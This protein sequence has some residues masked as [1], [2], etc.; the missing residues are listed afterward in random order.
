MFKVSRRPSVGGQGS[1]QMR[2]PVDITIILASP[3]ELGVQFDPSKDALLSSDGAYKAYKTV[4]VA[5]N[6]DGVANG[7]IV[8][9]WLNGSDWSHVFVI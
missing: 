6:V 9:S 8:N 2:L 1:G 5:G 4:H 7:D 3:T